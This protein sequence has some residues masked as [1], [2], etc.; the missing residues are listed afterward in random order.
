MNTWIWLVHHFLSVAIN[1]PVINHQEP[2]NFGNNDW[3]TKSWCYIVKVKDGE[4]C[5]VRPDFSIGRMTI[6]FPLKTGPSLQ[7]RG[8]VSLAAIRMAL[9][10]LVSHLCGVGITGYVRRNSPMPTLLS[11]DH[12]HYLTMTTIDHDGLFITITVINHHMHI[13]STHI[14]HD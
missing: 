3:F 12:C 14:K 5:S 11:S 10:G 8:G 7:V 13:P 2:S 6:S 4:P 9:T 1:E